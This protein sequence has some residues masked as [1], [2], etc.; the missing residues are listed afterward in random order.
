MLLRTLGGLS[1]EL[2]A[3][4]DGLRG[5]EES[6]L[7][8]EG[9]ARPCSS[10]TG[11]EPLSES[12]E[13]RGKP[14]LVLS[15]GDSLLLLPESTGEGLRCASPSPDGEVRCRCGGDSIHTEL[16]TSGPIVG[17]PERGMYSAGPSSAFS[18]SG[19]EMRALVDALNWPSGQRLLLWASQFPLGGDARPPPSSDPCDGTRRNGR[20]TPNGGLRDGDGARWR[21]SN[22]RRALFVGDSGDEGELGYSPSLFDSGDLL[23]Q[24]PCVLISASSVVRGRRMGIGCG[25][26]RAAAVA[27]AAAVSAS[28]GGG[29]PGGSVA[30]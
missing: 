10:E 15:E 26:L 11:G 4:N 3:C 23:A 19:D 29:D 18:V 1:G 9:D 13:R 14:R 16:T 22:T 2:P 20:D 8:F 27:S 5:D 7:A 6:S 21:E 25:G 12:D 17:A 24:R 30:C 28:A